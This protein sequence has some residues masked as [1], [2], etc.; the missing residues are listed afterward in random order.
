MWYLHR[1]PGVGASPVV[2]AVL[3]SRRCLQGEGLYGF[4]PFCSAN[5]VLTVKGVDLEE[6]AKVCLAFKMLSDP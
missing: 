5:V 3:L 4:N 2:E 1:P 6:V